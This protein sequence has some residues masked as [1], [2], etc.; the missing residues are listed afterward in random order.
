MVHADDLCEDEPGS[1]LLYL[2]GYEWTLPLEVNAAGIGS[3]KLSTMD[4]QGVWSPPLK[5]AIGLNAATTQEDYDIFMNGK[6]GANVLDKLPAC[7]HDLANAFSKKDAGTLPPHRPGIDHEIHLKPEGKAK[8][9]FRKPYPMHN[10]ANDAIKKW[11][12]EQLAA[13]L[14]RRSNSL[15]ASPVIVVKKPSGSLRMCVDYRPVNE[16]TIKSKYLIPL[17]RETLARLSGKRIF[18]KLDVIAAFNRIRI[19]E[20]YEWITVFNTRYS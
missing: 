18:T 12:D 11:I 16:M 1:E 9:P 14:I 7:Y 4:A 10:M 2:L 8:P 20:G 19:A 17:I 15:C 5:T 3:A 13:G 6:P